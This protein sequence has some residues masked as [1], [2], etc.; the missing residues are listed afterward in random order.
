MLSSAATLTPPKGRSYYFTGGK[1]PLRPQ[2]TRREPLG[3]TIEAGG[4][5][6]RGMVP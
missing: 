3:R 6:K 5:R 2:V 4:S 1:N